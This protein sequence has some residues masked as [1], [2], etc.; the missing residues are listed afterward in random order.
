MN[1]DQFFE[2]PVADQIRSISVALEILPPVAVFGLTN[3]K[4]RYRALSKMYHPDKW[5]TDPL[6]YPLA[7]DLQTAINA[8]WQEYN[9]GG[10]GQDGLLI[11]R[12]DLADIYLDGRNIKKIS[13]G[14]NDLIEREADILKKMNAH[15]D[16]E[17]HAQFYVP[18]LV[19]LRYN[20]DD[21]AINTIAYSE[22]VLPEQLFSLAQLA[23]AYDHHIPIKAAGWIWRR[24][25]AALALGH[26]IGVVHGAVTPDHILL[27]PGVQ[28]EKQH[29]GYLIDWAMAVDNDEPIGVMSAKWHELYPPEVALKQPA[30]PAVDIYMAAK[31]M[32]WAFMEMP[33]DMRRYFERCTN[34][35]N[36]A[37]GWKFVE[38]VNLWDD[39]MYNR[40]GWNKEFVALNFVAP[41]WTWWENA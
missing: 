32:L 17:A 28:G 10:T 22:D 27:K 9:S 39:L 23:R 41:D 4:E 6:V 20:D 16:F 30:T 2:L 3:G 37:R 19:G 31:S 29:R 8:E 1:K 21:M 36:F 33:P 25:L 35:S 24:V 11:A 15:H 13:R 5:K 14:D 34:P 12:G 26:M 18:R 38:L 40:L 7:E